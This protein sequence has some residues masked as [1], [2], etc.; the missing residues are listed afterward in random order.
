M[1]PRCKECVV[2]VAEA[3]PGEDFESVRLRC[4][5]SRDFKREYQAALETMQ[6]TRP[7]SFVAESFETERTL[8]FLLER[9]FIFVSEKDFE[10]QYGMAP[11]D[12]PGVVVDTILGET[13][14]PITGKKRKASPAQKN[15]GGPN[16]RAACV[17][18]L[19][20][21]S[22]AGESF[23]ETVASSVP[24][25]KKRVSSGS[26]STSVAAT[27]S[28]SPAAKMAAQAEKY[29]E[30]LNIPE[31]LGGANMGHHLHIARRTLEAME[32]ADKRNHLNVTLRG[33]IDLVEK[34][35]RLATAKI[36]SL[37]KKERLELSEEVLTAVSADELP[38]AFTTAYLS[39][40]LKDMPLTTD[41]EV[42]AW[43]EA[44]LPGRLRR[45]VG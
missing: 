22:Q 28:G 4:E 37:V 24:A 9:A 30:L 17:F 29:R 10:T 12:L 7:R 36:T 27:Q 33:H 18:S 21:A 23:V 45:S 13:G 25:N 15:K 35:Q 19:A 41:Q 1:E 2:L 16:K 39:R 14:Q 43:C 3:W 38:S 26:S 20:G 5:T 44:V 34:A 32:K 6:G 31:I 8:A 40:A 11:R 42:T